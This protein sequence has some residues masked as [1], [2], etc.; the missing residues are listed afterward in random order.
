MT[1]AYIG[2]GSNLGRPRFHLEAATAALAAL[3]RSRCLNTSA[4]YRSSPIGPPR[5]PDYL[6]RVVLLETELAPLE[7][8]QDLQAIEQR[9]GRVRGPQRWGPRTLDLDLL[10]YGR[11]Q[12]NS[13][14]LR[15]PHPQLQHRA[16]VLRPLYELDEKLDIPGLGPI[17]ELLPAVNDQEVRRLPESPPK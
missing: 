7:L 16:F 2:L 8:L 12:M 14:I 17:R 5:Q 10:L 9:Q 15:L 4:L 11:R 3:P 1:A 13:A 6:N